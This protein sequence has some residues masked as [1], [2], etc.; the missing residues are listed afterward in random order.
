MIPASAYEGYQTP[1]DAYETMLAKQIIAC[2][3]RQQEV[4]DSLQILHDSLTR[5]APKRTLLTLFQKDMLTYTQGLYIWGRVGRGK[6][7]LMDLFFHTIP[8]VEKRR[9]HFHAF[10]QEV[11]RRMHTLRQQKSEDLVRSLVEELAQNTR[12]LCF[13][14]LQA[15]DP[16]DGTLLYRL[17]EGLF[18]E[19]ITIVTTSNR[20]P[21]EIYSGV[22]ADRFSKFKT[23]L[24]E[25]LE[26]CALDSATD[27]RMQKKLHNSKRFVHPLGN[28]AGAFIEGIL[29]ILAKDCKGMPTELPVQGRVLTL[30]T[31]NGDIAEASFAELCNQPLGAADYL[32][33]AEHCEALI[34]TD[35][36]QITPEMRNEAKR[37]VT[38]IDVLYE[39][40]TE[41]YCTAEVPIEQLYAA[42]DGSFEFQRTV[43]RLTEMTGK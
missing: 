5:P 20:S 4:V 43:S 35:I 16:A 19:G 22:Q 3:P 29:H 30:I 27:Y 9:V 6:S 12:L 1:R 28:E 38:L 15:T 33:L 17:F 26:I 7:M 21:A 10:M 32:S 36:P 39:H 23:I 25:K 8:F 40:R 18:A 14:E 42:G 31:Y 11:H 13:D 24:Q 41:L 37:F 34:L 2:D